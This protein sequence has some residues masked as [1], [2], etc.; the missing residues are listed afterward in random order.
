MS[1]DREGTEQ[2]AEIRIPRRWLC[3]ARRI[4]RTPGNVALP[5]P[6]P[7]ADNLASISSSSGTPVYT[8]ARSATLAGM[9]RCHQQAE[10]A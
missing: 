4:R 5:F 10:D 3:G 9:L 1:L 6:W 2:H 8:K 7:L